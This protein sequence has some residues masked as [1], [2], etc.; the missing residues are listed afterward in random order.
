MLITGPS[1]NKYRRPLSVRT[2][3]LSDQA[4]L[5]LR[6][7]LRQRR[8]YSMS[9]I[10]RSRLRRFFALLVGCL[11]LT[12]ASLA[13]QVS[14]QFPLCQPSHSP[15]CPE[16]AGNS[17]ESCPVC[18]VS[19]SAALKED[20]QQERSESLARAENAR[21]SQPSRSAIASLPQ[22]TLGASHRPCVFAL[23]DDLR[24]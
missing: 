8:R 19:A 10:S 7:V 15:C 20:G 3:Y 17:S 14:A 16:P 24:I 18:Y 21:I 23:K 6:V 4:S 9:V 11:W 5:A 13:E 22:V 2:R 1:A 12:T